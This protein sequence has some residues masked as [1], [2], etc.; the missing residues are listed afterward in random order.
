MSVH[1]AATS[2]SV[3]SSCGVVR[4]HCFTPFTRSSALYA[5]QPEPYQIAHL[6]IQNPCLI[7]TLSHWPDWMTPAM[8]MVLF[9]R[10]G[11]GIS[12]SNCH[13][14]VDRKSLERYARAFPRICG[15]TSRWSSKAHARPCSYD[16][17]TNLLLVLIWLLK[18]SRA[19]G[20][21]SIIDQS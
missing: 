10:T 12:Y 17:R 9:E 14:N 11:L 15:R 1:A 18:S 3:I 13:A 6:C 20:I 4:S 7:Q 5:C 21:R 2:S 16:T 8:L 19:S